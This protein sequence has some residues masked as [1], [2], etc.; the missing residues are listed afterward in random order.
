MKFFVRVYL[1]DQIVNT[2]SADSK[3]HAKQIIK[4][5]EQRYNEAFIIKMEQEDE[6]LQ[7]V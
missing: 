5:L 4:K 6:Q 7:K 3:Y 1:N 2:I